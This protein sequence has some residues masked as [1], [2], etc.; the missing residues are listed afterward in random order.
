MTT[1]T[2]GPD[3]QYTDIQEAINAAKQGDTVLIKSGTYS[4]DTRLNL[5]SDLILTGEGP[6]TIL[7]ANADT[8]GSLGGTNHDGWL[9]CN[10]LKNVEICNM[11]LISSATG[12]SEGGHGNTRNCIMLNDCKEIKIHD[13]VVEKFVYNDFVR[14]R[15][16][17]HIYIYNNSGQCGHD[18]VEF[19][20]SNNC[21]AFNNDIVIQTNCGIRLYNAKNIKLHHNIITGVGGS[22]WCIFEIES[23]V[24]NCEIYNNICHDFR[25]SS[26]SFVTQAV[27]ASVR[28]L[29]VYDNVIWNCGSIASGESS[30]NIINPADLVIE[31]W[32]SKGYGIKSNIAPV[33]YPV[34][35]TTETEPVIKV[36]FKMKLSSNVV[37]ATIKFTDAVTG[38]TPT[39]WKWSFGDGTFSTEQSSTHVYTQAG[40]YTVIL[41]I[42]NNEKLNRQYIIKLKEQKTTKLVVGFDEKQKYNCKGTRVSP[43]DAPLISAAIQ[44]AHKNG[45]PTVE[46]IGPHTY[47]VNDTIVVPVDVK[48]TGQKGSQIVWNF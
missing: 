32:M 29:K 28:N 15:N 7:K 9:Y 5:K 35:L 38:I 43:T 14:C 48:L 8:G 4:L 6:N 25:G 45:I 42:N 33:F 3:Q 30:N 26:G 31:N 12:I 39:A 46:L 24:E 44:E 37:P 10:G 36:E 1:L 34:E 40:N 47:Y 16:G 27:H 41:T 11:T 2:I 13:I 18:F 17:Y 23:N 22:G 20:A 21:E 19:L